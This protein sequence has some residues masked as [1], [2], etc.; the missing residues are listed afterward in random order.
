MLVTRVAEALG[1]HTRV[2]TFDTIPAR[3][4]EVF[5]VEA[6]GNRGRVD[7]GNTTLHAAIDA[8]Q[9]SV[10][11]EAPTAAGPFWRAGTPPGG[12]MDIAVGG[13]RMTVTNVGAASGTTQTLT[14]V[15]SV[16]G[17]AKPHS[18]FGPGGATVRLWR[19]G[20]VAL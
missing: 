18:R 17:V 1:S 15:R 5:Q 2:M 4:Y 3:P 19:P 10:V 11:I 7:S 14:V 20:K 9:T 13:E 6:P 16:N 12:S 8:T